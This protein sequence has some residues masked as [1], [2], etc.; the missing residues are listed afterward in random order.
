MPGGE[1]GKILPKT[2]NEKTKIF[3]KLDKSAT[4]GCGE[5]LDLLEILVFLVFFYFQE[6]HARFSSWLFVFFLFVSS[7][8]MVFTCLGPGCVAVPRAAAAGAVSSWI[9]GRFQFF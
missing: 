7:F 8:P 3:Q 5:H 4:S 1:P 9:S 2:K 6:D